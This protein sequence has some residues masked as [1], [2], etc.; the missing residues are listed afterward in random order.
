MT[1][2]SGH[3]V[4][5]G[6]LDHLDLAVAIGGG[7]VAIAAGVSRGP[8]YGIVG[9]ALAVGLLAGLRRP[10]LVGY[11]AIAVVPVTSGIAR[12][13]PIP[14]LRV[15]EAVTVAA[16][17]IVLGRTAGRREFRWQTIDW[18]AATYVGLHAGLGLVA[19]SL[20]STLDSEGMQVLVGPI[21]FFL[22]YRVVRATVV[23]AEQRSTAVRIVILATMPVSLIAIAQYVGVPGVQDAVERLTRSGVFDL[24]GYSLQNRA[25]GPFESWHPLAGYLFLPMATCIA[26]YAEP[27]GRILSRWAVTTA[28]GLAVLALI[29]SQT[30]NVVAGVVIVAIVIAITTRRIRQILVPVVAVGIVGAVVFGPVFLARLDDQGVSDPTSDGLEAPQTISYR[31]EVWTDQY[32]PALA[33]HWM[34]GY[35]PELP[36]TIEWRST[37]SL[38][39]TLTLRGGVLLLASFAALALY[40]LREAWRRRR[41][42]DDAS[43]VVAV[44]MIGAT[45]ALVPMHAVFPYFTASGLPQVYWVLLALMVGPSIRI[46]HVR[47]RVSGG[48]KLLPAGQA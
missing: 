23:T 13:V 9:L 14:G 40:T 35:G 31:L 4:G 46:D 21:Q 44:A 38:Y 28:L 7:C 34:I 22:L 12:G 33:D 2:T 24:W 29:V 20:N 8:I 41:S 19:G 48:V 26:L 16:A 42:A 1:A 47:T 30:L 11:V 15:S 17:I 3:R 27:R 45:A 5:T 36:S 32:I 43:R 39:L 6:G 37:E 18:V 25:T 10:V